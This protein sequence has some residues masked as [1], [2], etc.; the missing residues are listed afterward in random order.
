MADFHF[1]QDE[2]VLLVLQTIL[3]IAGPN[4]QPPFDSSG[5]PY[6]GVQGNQDTLLQF[7]M[8]G[9]S[10]LSGY[11]EPS[12]T[13]SFI[14]GS[15]N[16]LLAAFAP[17][18]SAYAFILPIL[19]VIRGIIEVICALMNPFAVARAVIRL[20][21][22]WIPPFLSLF[23]PFA[24]AVLIMSVIKVILAI[25]FYI[26]TVVIPTIQLI[27]D[28]LKTLGIIASDQNI[29]E[30]QR[31]AQEEAVNAKI[32]SIIDILAQKTGI[33]GVLQP[34]LD[35]VFLILSL[36]SGFPCR[37]GKA[38]DTGI[39]GDPT[40]KEGL[41]STCCDEFCPEILSDRNAQPKGVGVLIPAFYG[42]CAPGFVF[43]LR[44]S[45]PKVAELEQYQENM[46]SQLN[47]QLDAPI[48][49]ARPA[50][51]TSDR[52]LI[53]VRLTSRRGNSRTAVL[54][55]LDI[56][57]T[58]IKISS[59]LA[60][61]FRGAVNYV[62]EPD[63]DMMLMSGIIG[64]GCHPDVK[65]TT[66]EIQDRFADIETPVTDRFPEIRSLPDDVRDI[67]NDIN[68]AIDG[69]RDAD[70]QGATDIQNNL[71]GRL[72]GFANNLNNLLNSMLNKLANSSASDLE[73]NKNAVTADTQDFATITITPR[74][75]TRLPL[76]RNL[77]NGV[78]LNVEIFT[79][80]GVISNQ[81]TDNASG[82]VIAE[83]RSASIGT[84]SISARINGQF[85]VDRDV[86]V[87]NVRTRKIKF[88]QEAILPARRRRSKP[89]SGKAINT[90]TGSDKE[91]GVG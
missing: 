15:I 79:D 20:F 80:F 89:S 2:N 57:G 74:D 65:A 35:L 11:S 61:L 16:S 31:E 73:V 22:K 44:T 5:Q 47:C 23:P 7:N 24:G 18:F 84:A 88:V 71:V 62:I 67:N 81:R 83:I 9:G 33:L 86:D 66:D 43:Q 3:D 60:R 40:Q 64:V 72:N 30:E 55:V 87:L 12:Q 70:I 90:G 34:I 49:R 75:I 78:G 59:P 41:D 56:R 58:T 1:I 63:Y 85:I 8:P 4:F 39:D 13:S 17:A 51:A 45:N 68:N 21:K 29:P 25:V 6:D 37:K 27:I 32:Q 36:I 76:I 82:T 19:G 14:G 54:P 69:L 26:L 52:S 38:A 91:P 77:P 48:R 46:E 53:K 42:D 10:Q 50:G 28:N